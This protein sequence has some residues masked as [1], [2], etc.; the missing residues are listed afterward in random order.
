[1]DNGAALHIKQSFAVLTVAAMFAVIIPFAPAS[2][3]SGLTIGVVTSQSS[4]NFSQG[5]PAHN[6][7]K[8]DVA[9]RETAAGQ[10]VTDAGHTLVWL[11]DA[12]LE[13][14][15]KLAAVDVVVLP[16]TWAMNENASLT[17]RSW[18]KQGGGLISV[19]TSPRVFLE[20][21]AWKLWVWELNYEAWE[22][23]PLSEAYQMMFDNDPWGGG[24]YPLNSWETAVQ[25]GHPITDGALA[26]LSLVSATLKRSDGAGVEFSHSYNGNVTSLLGYDGI[27]GAHSGYNGTSA[28][29]AIQYGSGRIVRFNIPILD[30]LPH[31]NAAL[32]GISVGPGHDQ[33]DLADSLLNEA[34]D[35][36]RNG[37]GYG[38]VVPSASTWGEVDSYGSEIYVRQWVKSTGTVPVTGTL[39]TKIFDPTGKLVFQGTKNNLGV[40]PGRTQGIYNWRF[41]NGGT[42]KNGKYR[43]LLEYRYTYP[44]YSIV[45]RAEAFVTRSQGKKIPTT[46]IIEPAT[47]PVLRGDFDDSGQ[48]DL[49][50]FD[51]ADGT[52]WVLESSGSNFKPTAWADFSTTSGWT[53]RMAGDFSG[54]GKDDIAQFHPSNGTWWISKSNGSAFTTSKW[55][56]FTTA[57]GWINRM[58]GDFS[59]DG[60]TDIAQFHPSNGTWWI[61]TST[62]S[63][64]TTS[65]WADYS[66]ASGWQAHMVGDFNGDGK[67][68]IAQFHPSNGTWWISTSTGNGFSTTLWADFTTASGWTKRM[69]GDFNGDGKD[70]IAQF[71]PSNGTWWVSR[72]TGSG[73]ITELWA[74]YSTASGWQ[75]TSVG[76]YNG[77]GKDDI[78]QFHPSNGTWWVSTSTGSGFSTRLWADYTTASGWSN[79][80][81]GDFSGDGKDDIAQFHSSNATWWVSK[82]NGSSFTTTKWAQFA[83]P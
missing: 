13:N 83:I 40:E 63:A 36:A 29:Q 56:D 21:G 76:D 7:A 45:S 14:P 52:W 58:V 72:S 43:V 28:A 65:L 4:R 3:A 51:P 74:D 8:T 39:T 38:S 12:D 77:D 27:T 60:K 44:N 10:W 61:S 18:V 19:L 22:W 49:A 73:F 55:A 57:S 34:A 26:N 79:R 31:Y 47:S 9:G 32:A 48:Q 16:Y 70:D 2:A 20:N 6:F 80:I 11:S 15:A 23:G 41:S 67:D 25:P 42:L 5:I 68:D 50:F 64:F 59:G 37:G 66:T 35:W 71:H 46:P 69:V 81:V 1:V 33:G 78:A 54:D 30:F 75:A 53:N 17:L 24:D 82:S 62:G